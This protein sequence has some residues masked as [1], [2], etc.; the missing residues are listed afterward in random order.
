MWDK[1]KHFI[2]VKGIN[3]LQAGGFLGVIIYFFFNSFMAFIV[4]LPLLIP[5]SKMITRNRITKKNK[6]LNLQFKDMLYALSSSLGAGYSLENSIKLLE[7]DLSQIYCNRKVQILYYVAIMKKQVELNVPIDKVLSDFT[8]QTGLEE[9]EN[10][11]NTVIT[12]RKTG[13]NIVRAVKT[14]SKTIGE[15]IDTKR[16]IDLM[17]AG[18]KFEQNVMLMFPFATIAF[19]KFSSPEFVSPLYETIVGRI[20]MSICLGV[21]ILAIFLGK[22]ILDIEV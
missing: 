14:A 16:E 20:I 6:E 22:K 3:Y 15:K 12:C 17:V 1:I 11:T 4:A 18:K 8:K 19:M 10:F 21:F 9:A 5:I 13:G 2:G 7:K